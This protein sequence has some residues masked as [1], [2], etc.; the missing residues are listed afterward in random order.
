[1]DDRKGGEGGGYALPVFLAHLLA[2]GCL[3]VTILAV[4]TGTWFAG[5]FALIALGIANRDDPKT[6]FAAAYVAV[7]LFFT[8]LCMCVPMWVVSGVVHFFQLPVPASGVF[9]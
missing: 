3:S 1:M 2:G 6:A 5:V 4:V 8:A 9:R 7:L